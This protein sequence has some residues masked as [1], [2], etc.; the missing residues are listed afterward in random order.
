MRVAVELRHLMALQAEQSADDAHDAAPHAAV[1]AMPL[2]AAPM[3]PL[4]RAERVGPDLWVCNELVGDMAVYRICFA[5]ALFFLFHS[6]VLIRV[7]TGREARAKYQNGYWGVKLV[8]FVGV[9]VGAFYMPDSFLHQF[10]YAALVGAFLF[11][12]IQLLLLVDFAHTWSE[13]WVE[14]WENSDDAR[15]YYALLGST[16]VLYLVA[17]VFTILMYVYFTKGDGECHLN[18]TFISLNLVFSVVI[19]ALSVSPWVQS[20]NPRSGLLQSSVVTMYATYLTWSAVSNEPSECAPDMAAAHS[21]SKVVGAL[22]T[23]VS[24]AYS[25]VRSGGRAESFGIDGGSLQ[26]DQRAALLSDRESGQGDDDDDDDG[27]K[28]DDGNDEAEGVRYNYSFFHFIFFL[29]S[30]YILELLTNWPPVKRVSE[31]GV[32]HA[33]PWASV[34]VKVVSAWLT[35]ALYTWS[36]IAP[37]VLGNCRDFD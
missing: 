27:G 10:G 20:E 24:I 11:I 37:I 13:R 26:Y 33:S 35:M 30:L 21:T 1:P 36:L 16:G 7:R 28:G 8:L 17:L 14:K 9:I 18:K 3:V 4:S 34:W 32:E 23:F 2:S 6:L 19:T 31:Q 5:M 15:W 22:L 25:S 29:A 12:L